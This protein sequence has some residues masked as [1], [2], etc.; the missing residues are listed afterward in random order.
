MGCGRSINIGASAR[1]RSTLLLANANAKADDKS[2]A[3]VEVRTH[4]GVKFAK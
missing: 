4:L 3:G 2:W 1:S